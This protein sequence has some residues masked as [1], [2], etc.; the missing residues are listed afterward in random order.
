MRYHP[1]PFD[2]VLINPTLGQLRV[3]LGQACWRA[4]GE[5]RLRTLERLSAAGVLGTSS[6]HREA[7]GSGGN[8]RRCTIS[9]LGLAWVTGADGRRHVRVLGGRVYPRA[10][11][12]GLFP[13]RAQPPRIEEMVYPQFLPRIA[14]L[15]GH[16]SIVQG[17]LL[18]ATEGDAKEK[19]GCYLVLADRLEE[20]GG[21]EDATLLRQGRWKEKPSQHVCRPPAPNRPPRRR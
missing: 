2:Q 12:W 18:Q 17:L 20:L 19:A 5:S 16:D 13:R 9:A 21:T 6:G 7:Q 1:Y 14:A 3:A 10:S 4:N 11:V 8:R 15:W